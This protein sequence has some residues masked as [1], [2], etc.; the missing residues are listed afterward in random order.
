MS[1]GVVVL[2][3]K[4]PDPN[5]TYEYR[6]AYIR[7]TLDLYG[8]FN[9]KTNH[10]DI[11]TDTVLDHFTE[12]TIWTDVDLAVDEAHRISLNITEFTDFE[13]EEGIIFFND[14]ADKLFTEI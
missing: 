6:V 5:F 14:L 11:N 7:E 10:Y 9:D 1:G 13:L 8:P 4:S 3:T 12:V 2:K